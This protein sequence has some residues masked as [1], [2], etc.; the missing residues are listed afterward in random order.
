MTRTEVCEFGSGNAEG[1]KKE[2]VGL[3]MS[4][5]SV[6]EEH[7]FVST[8]IKERCALG[9]LRLRQKKDNTYFIL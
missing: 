6:L 3:V 5:S 2:K 4:G 8:L 9:A 7:N 1:G